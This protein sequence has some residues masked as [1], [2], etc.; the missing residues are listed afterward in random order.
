MLF[1]SAVHCISE[2]IGALYDVPHGVANS[3]FLPHVL[4]YNLP[5]CVEKMANLARETGFGA[6][7]G[8]TDDSLVAQLFITHIRDLSTRLEIPGFKELN[9]ARDQFET[10]ADMSVANN[11]NPSNPRLLDREDYLKILENAFE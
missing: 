8:L 10:I 6:P 3:I 1:R 11:S 4:A 9:I 5:A 7:D 2:S